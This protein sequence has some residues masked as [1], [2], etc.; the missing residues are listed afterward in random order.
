VDGPGSIREIVLFLIFYLSAFLTGL[1]LTRVK[2]FSAPVATVPLG[3]MAIWLFWGLLVLLDEGRS[4]IA[5]G[6]GTLVV[7]VGFVASMGLAS[8]VGCIVA[9]KAS[10]RLA[11]FSVPWFQLAG[12]LAV[13]VCTSTVACVLRLVLMACRLANKELE[14]DLARA[15]AFCLFALLVIAAVTIANLVLLVVR[16]RQKSGPPVM[17]PTR[18]CQEPMPLP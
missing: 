2:P 14:P 16:T 6:W 3:T 1:I 17:G 4:W 12:A 18:P 7:R 13:L 8:L 10:S 11:R 15:L 5:P 9:T